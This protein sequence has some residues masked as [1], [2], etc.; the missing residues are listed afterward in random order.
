MVWIYCLTYEIG[1]QLCYIFLFVP[2]SMFLRILGLSFLAIFYDCYSI[3]LWCAIRLNI[4]LLYKST[5]LG[6]HILWCKFFILL[7]E[8]WRIVIISGTVHW[9]WLKTSFHPLLWT[10]SG[11]TWL[12]L[13]FIHYCGLHQVWPDEVH[14]SGWKLVFNQNQCTV[15]EIIT[16]LQDHI[17]CSFTAVFSGCSHVPLL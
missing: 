17:L 15:P 2:G 9:F 6:N 16:I 14:S 1:P 3:C 10:S 13:A 5:Y 4:Y 8:S 11:L 12:L 7:V